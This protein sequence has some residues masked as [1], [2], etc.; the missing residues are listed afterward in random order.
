MAQGHSFQVQDL[1][2]ILDRLRCGTDLLD[3]ALSA[4]ELYDQ[5]R[6]TPPGLLR[7]FGLLAHYTTF[8]AWSLIRDSGSLGLPGRGIYLTPT[9]QPAWL[10]TPDLGLARPVELCLIVESEG[11]SGVFGPGVAVPSPRFPEQ[12]RGGGIEFFVADPIPLSRIVQ[13]VECASGHSHAIAS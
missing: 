13:I 5:R 12:W 3:P 9:G 1:S 11:L 8:E 6:P 4:R 2:Q 7:R 10:A